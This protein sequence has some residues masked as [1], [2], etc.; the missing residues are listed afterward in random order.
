VGGA[1]ESR[2]AHGRLGRLR[3]PGAVWLL[4][5]LVAAATVVLYLKVVRHLDSLG[6]RAHVPWWA[7]A[8]G[9][10]A[11]ELFVIHFHFRRS[12]H[13]M[14][15][16]EVPL[17]IGLMLARPSAVL[18]AQLVAGAV[19]LGL[20]PG[21]S[22]IRFVFN[23]GLY[24]LV[25]CIAAI[26][27]HAVVP[28]DATLGPG[29]W[30]GAFAGT[31]LAS[32]AAVVLIASAITLSESWIGARRVLQMQALAL[33]IAVTNTSLGLAVAIVAAADPRGAWLLIVPTITLVIAY[34][35]YSSERQKHES[36]EFIHGA[37]RT[38]AREGDVGAAL[39]SLLSQ[40]LN[41][42]RGELAEIVLFPTEEGK[43]PLRTSVGG[44]GELMQPAPA[45]VAAA[46]QSAIQDGVP[47]ALQSP[48]PDELARYLEE[49]GVRN[50]MV[51]PLPGETR[52]VGAMLV[53][54][55]EGVAARFG[56]H[57]L[58]LFETLAN[59]VGVSLEHDRLEQTLWQLRELQ[60]RLEHQAFHDPLTGLA[61]RLLFSDRVEHALARRQGRVAVLFLDVDDFKMVNDRVGHAGGDDLLR[62]VAD[63]V[64][65]CLR[66]ADTPA[67]M[68]GDEFAILLEEVDENALLE[69]AERV[70]DSFREPFEVAG[71]ET[72]VTGSLGL[73]TNS[74]DEQAADLLRNADVAMYTAKSSGK[75]RFAVFAPTMHAEMLK[76]HSLK[77][78]LE[79]AIE[80]D[81]FVV[82]YQPITSL[83]TGETVALE[84]L[85]RWEHPERGLV[86]PCDFI[87][88][89]EETGLIIQIGRIVLR[90]AC[91]LAR[92]WSDARPG[93]APIGIHV[94][95]SAPELLEPDLLEHITSSLQESGVA[96]GQLVIE[97]TESLLLADT[98]RSVARLEELRAAGL[99][100]ALDDF[101][102]G[103]SSLSYLH[104]LPLD[105]LKMDKSFVSW[106]GHGGRGAAVAGTIADLARTL[107]LRLVAEGIETEEQLDSM[108]SLG[109]EMGQGYYFS[110]PMRP[111]VDERGQG[112]LVRAA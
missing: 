64:R 26:G 11:T 58:K 67:R 52:V 76:R 99:R 94:N 69:V 21:R 100:L 95:A 25:V 55:R 7:L 60:E 90:K 59:Q 93:S 63:R 53:A 107:G 12:A 33:A 75:G 50:G 54:N 37:T 8:V 89:A 5:L 44:D 22:L 2:R 32:V 97:I 35:A 86:P 6:A 72:R 84:A 43:P 91:L 51:A 77:E 112:L 87:P 40:T 109:C 41:A 10:A 28:A 70:I 18:L 56:S 80:R 39:Q 105:I 27:L 34:R 78:E 62:Q 1:R 65:A 98:P 79:A 3:G 110:P 31:A 14:S 49:R 85:V 24:G 104:R 92:A 20:S 102:T 83:E 4:N 73:A 101:G 61:N 29:A 38:L 103:Y 106:A 71:A 47:L 74:G 82:Y 23:L 88:L 111:G 57:D 17:V 13:S 30:L 15:L 46:L 96:P 45:H 16:G 66:P 68:G 42:F 81:E 108:R 48:F 19:T 36:L 9:F